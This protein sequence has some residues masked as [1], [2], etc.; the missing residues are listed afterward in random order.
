MI[1]KEIKGGTKK[2]FISMGVGVGVNSS[3]N[4]VITDAEKQTQQE[5]KQK[6]ASI[7]KMK[8]ERKVSKIFENKT[9]FSF[10]K[11]INYLKI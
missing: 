9:N 8:R 5:K 3:K 1:F 11:L 4:E 10:Y 6:P 2:T 7:G